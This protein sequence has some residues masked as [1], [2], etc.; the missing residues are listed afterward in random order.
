MSRNILNEKRIVKGGDAIN[1]TDVNSLLPTINVK[2]SKQTASTSIADTDLFVLEDASGNI[3]KITGANMKSEIEGTTAT[4]PLLLTGN[5]LSIKGLNGFTANKFL[6]VNS[7]GD[8]IEYADNPDTNFWERAIGY[9]K[10]VNQSDKLQLFSSISNDSTANS[11]FLD[12]LSFK[13]TTSSSAL[14]TFKYQINDT[15][16]NTTSN[17]KFKMVHYDS[18]TNTTTDIYSVDTSSILT[19]SKRLTLTN[20]LKQGS[21]DYTMPSATDTLVGR[22][23]TDTLQNKTLK[24]P[25]ILDTSD[26]H[27]YIFSVSELVANR[28]ITLPLLTGNDTFVFKDH[29]ETLSN[30]TL[31][32]PKIFDTS[33]NHSYI[34]GVSELVANRT[35]NLPLLTGND[36]FVFK[37]HTETL[38]NKTLKLPKILDTSDNHSY[39]F[40]VSELTADR[41]IN[42]PL[43]TGND[44]FVFKSHTETLSNKTFDD[45]TLF[46]EGIEIKQTATSGGIGNDS[47]F[48]KMWDEDNDKFI[49]LC[50]PEAVVGNFDIILPT[51][52]TTTT[53]LG[54][55]TTQNVS[56]KT[57]T[58]RTRFSDSLEVRYADATNV[59]GFVRFYERAD[60]GTHYTDLHTGGSTHTLSANRNVYIPDA[61]GTIALQETLP[62][63]LWTDSSNVY[64]PSNSS[65]TSIDLPQGTKIRDAGDTNDFIQF[66]D[67]VFKIDYYTIDIRDTCNIRNASNTTNTVLSIQNGYFIFIANEVLYKQT[68][69]LS[70]SSD[71]VNDYIQF[72]DNVLYVNY[73][74]MDFK[75]N[76]AL[77]NANQPSTDYLIFKDNYLYSNYASI[78]FKQGSKLSNDSDPT[79]D[80]LQFNDDE[81]YIN[82]NN[83][84]LKQGGSF[85]NA[86]NSLSGWFFDSAGVTY[87]TPVKI[88][89]PYTF[90]F[91]TRYP[92]EV[93][94]Y[95]TSPDT[96]GTAL[97]YADVSG[98]RA[99]AINGAVN[100]SIYSE[101]GLYVHTGTEI[102]VASDERVK[103]DIQPYTNGL[104]L[105]RK[106]EVVSYKY[107]DGKGK[108]PKHTEI[109]FIAQKV[110]EIYPNAVSIN[111]EYIPNVYKKIECIFSDF[112]NKFKMKSIDLP[113]VDNIDY[114]F[115]CWNEGDYTETLQMIIGN[116]DN[117]FTFDKKWD[118]VFCIGNK[119]NDFNILDKQSLF[120]INF[121]AT[122][123]LDNIVKQQQ[124]KIEE[125]Q[126]EIEILKD[127]MNELITSKSFADFKK[128][129]S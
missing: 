98:N 24:L 126:K 48:I 58:D 88:D 61:T 83:I 75:V 129:I 122:K 50:A 13:N 51:I 40:S 104:D 120:T 109:G 28:T 32:L 105:L 68:C 35:I 46:K 2:I 85:K 37:D 102:W 57:F 33:D 121:S 67:N 66:N 39:I 80:Y 20:G 26:N 56:N 118:N 91:P 29:T 53:L 95:L 69:K 92:L 110:K 49:L 116:S 9:I 96:T 52:T 3:K 113:N 5:D 123:E 97:Y 63:A 82:Y 43:L 19:F 45:L 70:N 107:I 15:S 27:S 72:N 128:K 7:A 119:V 78:Q 17:A 86:S 100:M 6:K 99:I 65:I 84:A 81:L 25:K 21:Y 115:Y 60:N 103:K 101:F 64:S 18:D 1:I 55:S 10:P 114:K 34:F 124:I 125:Q 36:T 54:D 44:T 106:L 77:R 47:A 90:P 11:T 79:N 117:T 38:S 23:T 4:L 111:Q 31:K 89:S 22:I 62:T 112:E 16:S 127:F 12:I 42:L 41:T 74:N 93:Y 71:A 59:S 87:A 76:T 73:A 30:K 94:G 108:E 14:A 8:S